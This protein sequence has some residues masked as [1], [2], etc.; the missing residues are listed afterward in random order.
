MAHEVRVTAAFSDDTKPDK[1]PQVEV[2]FI[3]R[4][5]SG[6][7]TAEFQKKNIPTLTAAL[8]A[9]AAEQAP[10]LAAEDGPSQRPEVKR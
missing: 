10:K 3:Q 1:A 9:A 7:A 8:T 4:E 5:M 2:I 6:R